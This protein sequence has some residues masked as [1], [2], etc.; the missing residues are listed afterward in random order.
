[1]RILSIA[2]GSS[3]NCIYAGTDDTNILID[4]GISN[5]KIEEGLR[6]AGISGSNIDAV[7]ITHEHSDHIKGIGVLARKYNLPIYGTKATLEAVQSDISTGSVPRE[8]F[9]V[10]HPDDEFRVGS[11]TLHP[12]HIY[13]DAADPVGYRVTDGKSA[14]AVATDLGHYDDYIISNLENLNAIILEANHD[15]HMLEAGSYPYRLKRR[16]LS[17][18]GHL[19]NENCGRL[20]CRILN[21]DLKYILLGHLSKENNYPDL[22]FE[23]VRCE[24][25]QDECPYSPDELQIIV[26]KRDTPSELYII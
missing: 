1:M 17:D 25:A 20:I 2:S 23:A 14:F 16:I 12:F 26:A 15:I 9:H 6:E 8:L 13:H 19:S 5:K 18:S 22:A 24:I 21:D 11:V 10:I 4:A 7:C 3:G